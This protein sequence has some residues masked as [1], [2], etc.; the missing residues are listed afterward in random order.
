MS[1]YLI[2]FEGYRQVAQILQNAQFTMQDTHWKGNQVG[3]FMDSF[4]TDFKVVFKLLFFSQGGEGG[5][6]TIEICIT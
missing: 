1:Y 6:R 5:V 4:I 2:I 3:F